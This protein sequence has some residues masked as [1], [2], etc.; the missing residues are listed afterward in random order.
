MLALFLT[1]FSVPAGEEEGAALRI[2]ASLDAMGSVYTVVAYGTQRN[3]IEAAV[4]E[5]FDEVRRLDA[6][7]SNYRPSSE[8]SRVNRLASTAPVR[9]SAELFALLEACQNYSRASQG[10]FD[11]SVGPLM[12]IWGFY[13]GEGRLAPGGEIRAALDRVGWR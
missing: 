10:A 12:K 13:K 6:M 7:L 1:G 2:E 8:W 5:A 3:R 9:V 4:E 11:V